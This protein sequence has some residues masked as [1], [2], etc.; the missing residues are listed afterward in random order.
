MRPSPARLHVAGW[1]AL[2][3]SLLAGLTIGGSG[4]GVGAALA[5]LGGRGDDFALTVMREIRLPRAL[6][7]AAVGAALSL[8][9]LLMQAV[10]INPLADPYIV[11]AAS[12]ASLGAALAIL[13]G[14]SLSYAGQSGVAM[15][16]FL[17]ALAAVALAW[18]IAG[19]ARRTDPFRLL[20]TGVALGM[21]V[22]ALTSL[23]MLL[24]RTALEQAFFWLVGGFAAA[25]WPQLPPVLITLGIALVF[26]APAMAAMN[27]LLLGDESAGRLGIDPARLRT[28]L[29]LLATLLTGA[30]V[31]AAGVVS[32]VGLM[33]PHALRRVAGPDHR[34]LFWL[35]PLWGAAALC[36][37]DAAGR[38]A[39][40]ALAGGREIPVGVITAAIGVPLMLALLRRR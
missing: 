5:A 36:A 22:S 10:F 24:S 16:A 1:L 23:L 40:G 21:L 12:G 8:A 6:L 34:T 33:V 19:G 39:S 38:W 11:G 18:R 20:L 35:C 17:G 15:C 29:I 2:A 32:F 3:L 9:G 25:S 30:A 27:L 14:L 26:G 37:A 4:L 7:A 13:A 31:A 28:R